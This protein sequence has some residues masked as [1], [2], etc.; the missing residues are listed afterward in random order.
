MWPFSKKQDPDDDFVALFDLDGLPRD[1]E[2][3]PLETQ[4]E[5]PWD[6]D[7]ELYTS[8][9]SPAPGHPHR[10]LGTES[11]A[12]EGHDDDQLAVTKW[13]RRT[14]AVLPALLESWTTHRQNLQQVRAEAVT[15]RNGLVTMIDDLRDQLAE[16]DQKYSGSSVV[17]TALT[18][19]LTFFLAGVETL[20]L[21]P[22]LGQVLA[23]SG[24]AAM[25]SS[26]MSVVL[27]IGAGWGVGALLHRGLLYEGPTRVR[28]T[29]FALATMLTAA[30]GA[31][32]VGIIA[33]R[34]MVSDP[35]FTSHEDAVMTAVLWAGI[36]L[37]AQVLAFWDGWRRNNP[38]V[39]EIVAAEGRLEAC[40][41]TIDAIDAEQ[42]IVDEEVELLTQFS[43]LAWVADHRTQIA[44]RYTE[45]TH[46][47]RK[48]LGASLIATGHDEAADLLL[49]L[50][51]PAF[52]PPVDTD[53]NDPGDDWLHGFVL[54]L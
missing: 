54:P 47:F 36:Q 53:W 26:L 28:R 17:G 12:V 52:I 13:L 44:K 19:F 31:I 33:V 10:C 34:V 40:E 23:V 30:G 11:Q 18:R 45:R 16:P 39:N 41:D 3:P 1:V 27:G 9:G 5:V 15:E 37:T 42:Q 24:A 35:R 22:V 7:V 29:H 46:Q 43:L 21:Y 2:P 6:A 8:I 51:M 50:P 48:E 38:R 32:L 20:A 49:I 4:E 25:A 14:A